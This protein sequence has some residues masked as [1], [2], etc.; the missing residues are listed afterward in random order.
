MLRGAS[1][2][3]PAGAC[4][5]R[6][7]TDDPAG[8]DDPMQARIISDVRAFGWHVLGI[9]S[10]RSPDWAYSIGMWHTFRSPDLAIFGLPTDHA[11]SLINDVGARVREGSPLQTDDRLGDLLTSGLDLTTRPVDPGW[12][13]AV[14]GQGVRFAVVP[15]WPVLQVVWPDRSG[16]FP[17]QAGF[18]PGFVQDQPRL[19]L[20]PTDHP[21]GRWSSLLAPDPWPF[22]DDVDAR[23]F[24]T[25]RV[26]EEQAP[27]LWVYH[28]ADG[29]WQFID[30]GPTEQE[31]IALVHLGHLVGADTSLAELADLPLGWMASRPATGDP[32][33]R[34]PR[35][36]DPRASE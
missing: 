29:D 23:V 21:L 24:T 10:E 14:F 34:R 32:W 35:A 8:S 3:P 25:R 20:R 31:D 33:S 36:S 2:S 28:D 13:P 16:R 1:D 18:D 9:S 15:P 19:W 27:I 4:S 22:S 6:I 11:I 26:V 17:W 7:C 12:Y 30:D 5:C